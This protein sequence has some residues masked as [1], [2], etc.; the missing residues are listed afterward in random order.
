MKKQEGDQT[1]MSG[2]LSI[3]YLAPTEVSDR[4]TSKKMWHQ[5]GMDLTCREFVEFVAD[6][7]S[8]EL[9]PEQLM[10]CEVHLAHCPDCIKYYRSYQETILFSKAAFAERNDRTTAHLPQELARSILAA[11]RR[12]KE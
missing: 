10:H 3:K 5:N 11:A 4:D 9:E 12:T 7:L 6:Y 1:E 8:G 2:R